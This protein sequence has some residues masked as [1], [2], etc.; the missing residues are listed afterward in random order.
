[1]VILGAIGGCALTLTADSTDVTVT[2]DQVYAGDTVEITVS[3]FPVDFSLPAD[4]VTLGGVRLPLPGIF[5]RPGLRPQTNADGQTTFTTTLPADVPSG[6]QTL[7][8]TTANGSGQVTASVTILVPSISI[9]PNLAVPNQP[10]IITGTGFTPA[11]SGTGRLGAHQITGIGTS[12]ISASGTAMG[13]SYATYPIDVDTD[14][15]LYA[16]FRVPS[17]YV[18]HSGGS[19]VIKVRDSGNRTASVDLALLRPEIYLVPATSGA[20]DKIQVIGYGFPANSGI[21]SG[22]QRIKVTYKDLKVATAIPDSYGSFST[23]IEVPR[24][25]AIS[26]SNTVTAAP[27]SCAGNLSATAAHKVPSRS[28]TVTPNLTWPGATVTITG[29]SYSA[30]AIMSQA[31]LDA[32]TTVVEGVSTTTGTSVLPASTQVG[33]DGGFSFTLVVPAATTVG[34]HTALVTA[35]GLTSS[36]SFVVVKEADVPIPTP[37]PTSP[38]LPTP[39]P[40]PPQSTSPATGIEPL[41][42]RLVRIWSF[43]NAD[44]WTFHDPRPKYTEFVN[45]THLIP[46]R[47]YWIEMQSD[48]QVALNGRER[49]LRQGWNLITW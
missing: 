41:G 16:R 28:I 32:T 47:P 13:T 45:L 31:F 19:I 15:G 34:G 17:S 23:T 48:Q 27:E 18:F 35:A 30:F 1:M 26:S 11:P 2:P 22:C 38:P 7:A 14:G 21:N 39:T 5:G 8:V 36:T 20:G 24:A 3:G 49:K 42:D 33:A 40:G 12:I 29:V 44:G 10:V 9:Y 25:T 4:S 43:G 6:P 46:G 37:T